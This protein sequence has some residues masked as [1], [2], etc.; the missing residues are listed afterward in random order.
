MLEIADCGMQTSNCAPRPL[1]SRLFHAT[2]GSDFTQQQCA[3]SCRLQGDSMSIPRQ[4]ASTHGCDAWRQRVGAFA[5]LPAF[6]RAIDLDPATVLANAG[7]APDALERPDDQIRYDALG[8]LLQTCA[9]RAAYPHFGLTAGRMWRLEDLGVLGELARN[10]A[11]VGEALQTLIAYQ[12]LN[13]EG[14]LAFAARQGSLVEFGYAI[15][16]P[17]VVGATQIYDYALAAT[18]NLLRELCGTGWLP[19]Q[20]LIP[21][22]KP[23]E[24]V[25]HRNL[26]K[27]LPQFDSEICAI[28]FPAC[29]MDHKLDGADPERRK[30][31]LST[32]LDADPPDLLQQVYRTLRDLLLRGR[33]SGNDVARALSMHRRTLNRRLQECGTTFQSVLDEVR[34]EVARQLLCYSSVA[35]DDIAASLGY[36][37]VSPF[38]RGFR[39]WTGL[40]PGR[41]RRL[42]VKGG[43]DF[44]VGVPDAS[45]VRLAASFQVDGSRPRGPHVA[46]TRTAVDRPGGNH[47]AVLEQPC[48]ASPSSSPCANQWCA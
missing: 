29:W 22:A 36:A 12:H 47:P 40:S 43:E 46:L 4:H 17:G 28:R 2:G 35:L 21:H 5:G 14:G 27:V 1:T 38:M 10:S 45:S 23:G 41:L 13:S 44:G 6:M 33:A 20:V 25:H 48:R 3:L 11:T 7:L 26:F 39:R 15:Y 16:Y 37:G 18:Y 8:R 24:A 32:I 19:T 9:D 34:C 42:A 31:A 30:R